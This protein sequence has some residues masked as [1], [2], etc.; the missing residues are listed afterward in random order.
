MTFKQRRQIILIEIKRLIG[1]V[2]PETLG[3]SG[4]TELFSGTRKQQF[5]VTDLYLPALWGLRIRFPAWTR[6][7]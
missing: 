6:N 2:T 4:T 3:D 1:F 7:F 5:G